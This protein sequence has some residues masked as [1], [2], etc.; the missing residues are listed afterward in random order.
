MSGQLSLPQQV[1]ATLQIEMM[2]EDPGMQFAAFMLQKDFSDSHFQYMFQGVHMLSFMQTVNKDFTAGIQGM[3]IPQRGNTCLFNY[4]GK[5]N[6]GQN[7]A[8]FN[9]SPNA[10]Q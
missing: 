8:C 7:S 5:Y 9:Y 1:K 6:F 4:T 3:F 2:G 10:M